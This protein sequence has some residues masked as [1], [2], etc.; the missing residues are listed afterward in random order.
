MLQRFHYFTIIFCGFSLT[1]AAWGFACRSGGF[2]PQ[3][4]VVPS[5]VVLADSWP[6][7]YFGLLLWQIITNLFVHIPWKYA[8]AGLRIIGLFF[9]YV[10]QFFAMKSQSRSS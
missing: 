6:G 4:L 7:G 5:V 9:H 3:H 10:W 8:V 1:H 2:A